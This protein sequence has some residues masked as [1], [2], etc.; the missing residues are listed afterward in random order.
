MFWRRK[1]LKYDILIPPLQKPFSEFNAQEAKD[2]FQWH[3]S[4][5]PSRIA[6]LSQYSGVDFD[7]SV[8]SL[9]KLWK[10][11]LYNAEIEKKPKA[12]LMDTYKR[13]VAYDV[14]LA[15]HVVETDTQQLSLETEYIIRDIAMYVGEMFTHNHPSIAWTYYTDTNIDSF[16]NMPV[17]R[18]FVDN[19]FTPPF[20]ATFEPNH[21][22]GVQ[23][24]RMLRGAESPLDMAKLY[25]K[26][27]E[28]I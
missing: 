24:A 6:Y 9:K 27:C 26:W 14:N 21:M 17:L 8:S 7:F 10:W 12:Q 25:L 16:A 22:V 11:F 3:M 28:M 19:D 2:F 5:I 20:Y 13:I 4:Q 15:A 23:A 18:G 1:K